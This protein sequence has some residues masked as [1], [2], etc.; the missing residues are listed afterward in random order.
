MRIIRRHSLATRLTHWINAFSLC[1]LLMS[2]LQI[3]N[4][5]PALY[6]GQTG[7]Q[8]DPA[9]LAITATRQGDSLQGRLHLGGLT[10]PTTGLL[11]VSQLDGAPVQ[12]AVPGWA[13]LPSVQDLAAGRRWHFF[14]AWLL[15]INGSAYLL[16]GAL[17]RH[18][19]RDL[20]PRRAE[21][22][23]RRLGHEIADH[24]RLRFPKGDAARRYNPLQKLAYLGVIFLLLPLMVLTGL[25]MSPGFDAIV[26]HLSDLFA[27]RQSART[28]H[29]ITA[30][31]LVLFVLVHLV[32]VVLSGAWNNLRSMVTGR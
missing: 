11:G 29:F 7:Q 5:H 4:A 12:R 3:F 17:D 21:L 8:G 22:S 14:F 18:F 30:S 26:P 28:I 23:P 32:M 10:L 25:T 1:I 24:L 20:L 15:V 27:G 16:C 2:G 31:L 13:T 9:L 19:S 6:W